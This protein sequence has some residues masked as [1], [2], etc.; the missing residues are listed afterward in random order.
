MSNLVKAMV[1]GILVHFPW[2][3]PLHHLPQL[4]AVLQRN[5]VTHKLQLGLKVLIVSIVGIGATAAF[6]LLHNSF[7]TKKKKENSS[8]EQVKVF[9][10]KGK[11]N[12]NLM[13]YCK[14]YVYKMVF[15]KIV[16]EFKVSCKIEMVRIF[17]FAFL[18]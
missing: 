6:Q 3:H 15:G 18:F 12:L 1:M 4:E 13:F 17:F 8:K 9:G 2:Q 11:A 14:I 7:P 16:D 5:L 10:V